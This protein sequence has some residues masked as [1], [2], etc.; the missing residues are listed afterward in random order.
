MTNATDIELRPRHWWTIGFVLIGLLLGCG[1]GFVL[2]PIGS[3]VLELLGG[4]PAPVR[5]AMT[6]PLV[7]QVPVLGVLGGLLGLFVAAE[8][9]KAA[10]KLTVSDDRLIFDQHGHTRVVPRGTI[11]AIFADGKDLVVNGAADRQIVRYKATDI[12][13]DA[14]ADALRTH[15]YPWTGATD[16]HEHEYSPWVDGSGETTEDEDHAFR[17]RRRALEK[18]DRHDAESALD[19]LHS[20]GLVVRDRRGGQEFRRLDSK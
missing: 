6:L 2:N 11:S 15:R 3:W 4:V 20:F 5:I 19:R 18:K 7:W 13:I 12:S 14:V 8:G 9:E 16:P 17:A 10:L 1:V